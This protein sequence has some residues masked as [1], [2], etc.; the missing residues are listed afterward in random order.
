MSGKGAFPQQHRGKKSPQQQGSERNHSGRHCTRT[1][2]RP[3]ERKKN[4]QVRLEHGDLVKKL[5]TENPDTMQTDRR[6]E[7]S[8]PDRQPPQEQ[9]SK[10]EGGYTPEEQRP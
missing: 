1:L 8:C 9:P 5:L 4:R 6:M 2:R 3:D 7:R 10:K